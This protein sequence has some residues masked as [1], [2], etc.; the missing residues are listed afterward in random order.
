MKCCSKIIIRAWRLIAQSATAGICAHYLEEPEGSTT[1]LTITTED[2]HA[3]ILGTWEWAHFPTTTACVHCW[4]PRYRPS[5]QLLPV[6]GSI[7]Q[8]NKEVPTPSTADTCMH[9]LGTQGS[10]Y[11]ACTATAG[12]H[13]HMPPKGLGIGLP[14]LLM[15]LPLYVPLRDLKV[16]WHPLLP[17][18]TTCILLGGKGLIHALHPPLPLPSPKQ[19]V[20]RPKKEP[21]QTHQYQ[22]PHHH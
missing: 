8:R 7:I 6:Y 18:L 10:T 9:L 5:L 4:G 3:H 20:W 16:G 19:A 17:P 13:L 12:I 15:P 2:I 21:A 1:P 22:C 14:S 11:P